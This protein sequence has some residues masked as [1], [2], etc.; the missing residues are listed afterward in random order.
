M[1]RRITAGNDAPFRWAV[2]LQGQPFDLSGKDVK[3]YV[4]NSRGEIPVARLTI[5]GHE[6]SGAFEGRYQTRLGEHSL[7][8]RVNEGRPEMKT[9]SVANVFELVQWSAEAG[10]S[11]EGDVIVAPVLIESELSIGG[12]SSYD[13][14]E[15]KNELARLEREKADKSEL[16][17]LS[18]EVSGLSERVDE[19]GE[20]GSDIFKAIYRETTIEE[21]TEAYNAGKVIHCDYDGYCYTLAKFNNG[22]A[23]FAA[24]AANYNFRI[25]LSPDSSWG[26]PEVFTLE[27]T[28]N[29]TKTINSA[30]TDTQY[31]S[32]KAV[33]EA[34][35]NVGG[36]SDVF[37]A[38]YGSTTYDEIMAAHNEGKVVLCY[39]D[40][41]W[42][43]RLEKVQTSQVML[44]AYAEH[45]VVRLVCNNKGQWTMASFSTEHY[46]KTLDNGNVEVKIGARTA[47]VATPQYVENAIQQSG[48]GG[49]SSD[50]QGVIRQTQTW[51]QA[52]DK[53]YDY[54]MQDIVRG[55]IPSYFID[56]WKSRGGNTATFNEATG[57]FEYEYLKDI[58]YEEALFAYS[59]A[60]PTFAP[61]Q[62]ANFD[63]GR[64]TL[65][66]ITNGGSNGQI[67]LNTTFTRCSLF[68]CI[69]LKDLDINES[70]IVSMNTAF[71]NC[72]KLKEIVGV[73]TVKNITT[74][75]DAIFNNCYSLE[76][77]RLK[78]IKASIG[79]A[80]SA[81]LSKDSVLYMIQNAQSSPNIT[82]KLHSDV[83]DRLEGDADIEAAK[84]AH[85]NVTLAK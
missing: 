59:I 77:V 47:E 29:K 66:Q 10:G 62:F 85:P 36:G 58:S 72:E 73:I 8:L 28:S 82:I 60:V 16:T 70:I 4:I 32:A 23:F 33:Y 80:A 45:S 5:E 84:A 54:V 26:A 48:G 22:T 67:G 34:L 75:G 83:Y 18:A 20:G 50:K 17:E 44:Q 30:S 41:N 31:P 69:S 51:T 6:V 40:N 27:L 76:E 64:F 2:K 65:P 49:A 79:F 14:T 21:V 13:D 43:A 39:Y 24:T 15:V 37:W 81:R 56:L 11:D 19:L 38:T 1:S 68:E 74:L 71:Y 3:V 55:S 12:G 61:Y 78:Q 52:A 9:A 63:K 57:Y 25:V 46:L 35:Q 7:V 42:V 53:G